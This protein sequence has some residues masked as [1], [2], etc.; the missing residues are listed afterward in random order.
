MM[1]AS[2]KPRRA[3]RNKRRTVSAMKYIPLL[4]A[5]EED[6]PLL[7][8]IAYEYRFMRM[9]DWTA[10]EIGLFWDKVCHYDDI[11]ASS[12]TYYKRF[13]DA[14][15]VCSIR[16][17]AKVLDISCRT[18]NGS[19]FFHRK[20]KI[21]YA[22]AADYSARFLEICGGLLTKNGVPHETVKLTDYR[23]DF[24]DDSFDAVLSFETVE[25]VSDPELFLSELARVCKKNGNV[26]ITTPNRLW[27]PVH[28][29]AAI[30]KI[31]HSEGPHRFLGRHRLIRA[32]R[33]AGLRV[34]KE[35]TTIILP[36]GPE[37]LLALSRRFEDATQR[38][39]ARWLALRRI[40]SC[41]KI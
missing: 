26:L 6:L 22:V 25:H 9:T 24:P 7:S 14:E 41:I 18:G 29:L 19:L 32:I 30:L 15:A 8:R 40:F 13:L 33:S 37:I 31:H 2:V 10:P 17:G 36:G 20:R 3:G 1:S 27:E 5:Y 21:G 4:K 34:D 28:W 23:L 12:Y 11:N 16:E 35:R 38:S 39:A